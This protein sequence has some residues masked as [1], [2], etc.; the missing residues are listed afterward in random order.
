M[1]FENVVNVGYF[2]H[3]VSIFVYVFTLTVGVAHQGIFQSAYGSVSAG[4][5]KGA[6]CGI[7][8]KQLKLQC[9]QTFDFFKFAQLF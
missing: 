7:F 2:K 1:L 5:G 9:D 3:S 4:R 6:K 8:F